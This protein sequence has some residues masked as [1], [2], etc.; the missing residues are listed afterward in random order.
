[1]STPEQY[2]AIVIGTGEA[3]KFIA[4]HLGSQGQHVAAIEKDEIG[5]ACPNVACLPTKNVVHSAKVASFFQRGTEF[6]IVHGEWHVDMAGVRARRQKMIDGLHDVHLGNFKKSGAEIIKGFGRFLDA[7]TVQ[8]DLNAGGTRTL[9]APKI[10]IDTGSRAT[11]EPIPGLREAQPLTH[12]QAL[13]L[14]TLPEH[15]LILGGGY[16]G[17]EFAQAMRRFGSR[18]TV[19]ERNDRMAHRED[20]DISEAIHQLFADEDI[21]VITNATIT[22]VEGISGSSV[23]LHVTQPTGQTIL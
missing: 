3:G 11:V 7:N 8:V 21:D 10:F 19:V 12:I 9:T 18:V 22:S 23:K 17:L 20:P 13:E 4:W 16:V 6:G 1:M 14:D 5:G 2:D 15:V